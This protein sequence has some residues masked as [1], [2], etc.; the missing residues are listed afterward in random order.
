MRNFF[1]ILKFD[2][3]RSHFLSRKPSFEEPFSRI[4]ATI[5]KWCLGGHT[6]RAPKDKEF[7]GDVFII[8]V[9]ARKMILE[10]PNSAI[11]EMGV[12]GFFVVRVT[13]DR[14]K[15]KAPRPTAAKNHIFADFKRFIVRK[16][17]LAI[18]VNA[19]IQLIDTN[20]TRKC[21]AEY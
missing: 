3:D 10:I 2:V 14:D 15:K 16:I 12:H 5:K 1:V 17:C 19:E 20:K 9:D 7:S 11:Q 6:N 13:D 21:G 18:K 8:S 4:E